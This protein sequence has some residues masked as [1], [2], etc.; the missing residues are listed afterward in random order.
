MIEG[1]TVLS[2]AAH[3]GTVLRVCKSAAGFYIGFRDEDGLP[4]SRESKY[5]ASQAEAAAFL[6][7]LRV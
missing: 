3:P 6:L 2:G 5:F 1:E 4:Y 7:H